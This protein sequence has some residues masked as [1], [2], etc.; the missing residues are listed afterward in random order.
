M[1][2]SPITRVHLNLTLA[3]CYDKCITQYG[4]DPSSSEM[5]YCQIECAASGLGPVCVGDECPEVKRHD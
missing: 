1:A 2:P 3:Q 4:T 5:H